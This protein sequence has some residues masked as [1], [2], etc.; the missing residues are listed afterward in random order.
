MKFS[1]QTN[2][3]SDQSEKNHKPSPHSWDSMMSTKSAPAKDVDESSGCSEVGA[4]AYCYPPS[5]PTGGRGVLATNPTL[6][7][8]GGWQNAMLQA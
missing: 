6:G 1:F 5:P 4:W 2:S 3:Y 7:R 8:D